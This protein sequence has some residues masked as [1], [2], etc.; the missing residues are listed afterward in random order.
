MNY[1]NTKSTSGFTVDDACFCTYNQRIP[2]VGVTPP[3]L[4]ANELLPNGATEEG[5][6]K[7]GGMNFLQAGDQYNINTVSGSLRNANYQ[8]RADPLL[9][10]LLNNCPGTLQP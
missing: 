9:Q 7:L 5:D 8:L 1:S 4:T 2:D 3:P 6:N 10:K